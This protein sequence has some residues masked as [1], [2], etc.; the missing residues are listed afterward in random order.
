[1]GSRPSLALLAAAPDVQE[2]DSLDDAADS[3]SILNLNVSSV[4]MCA[5]LDDGTV[6][7]ADDEV[8]KTALRTAKKDGHAVAC[9][10]CLY[11]VENAAINL[12]ATQ[13]HRVCFNTFELDDRVPVEADDLWILPGPQWN[14]F[15]ATVLEAAKGIQDESTLR[16]L[17]KTLMGQATAAVADSRDGNFTVSDWAVAKL[18]ELRAAAAADGSGAPNKNK[19]PVR[20]QP[21]KTPTAVGQPPSRSFP[22]PGTSTAAAPCQWH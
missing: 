6:D 8:W 20:P 17:A 12:D 18:K 16:G 22:T 7:S 15:K 11:S 13:E 9:L 14:R 2:S 3:A 1:M 5:K 21:A 4:F 10:R 19:S